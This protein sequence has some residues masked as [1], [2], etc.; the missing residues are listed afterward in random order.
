MTPY[1]QIGECVVSTRDQDYFFRP[2][3][4]AIASIGEPS[5]IV[6][7]FYELHR[8]PTAPLLTAAK[9]AFGLYPSWLVEHIRRPQFLK[10]AIYAAMTVLQACCEKDIT[11]LIGEL[12]PSRSGRWGMVYRKGAL[13]QEEMILIARSLI[14]HG[15]IG[16][17]KIR[18]LQRHEGSKSTGFD[19]FSYISAARQHLGMSR[20]EA[21]QLTMTE[22][23]IML[24]A[25]YPNQKGLTRDEYDA[26]RDDYFAS[27]DKKAEQRRKAR[28]KKIKNPPRRV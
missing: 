22:F 7:T 23:Q 10:P 25:K 20:A 12:V 9:E 15:I 6:Q 16:K 4:T 26:V 14:T 17:A 19:A 24:N 28:E 5:E 8:D 21:E 11:P 27:R 3:F 1:K 13:A 2:S 18:Q